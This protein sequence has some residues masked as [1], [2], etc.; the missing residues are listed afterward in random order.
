MRTLG[1]ALLALLTLNARA[2][3][4]TNVET[5]MRATHTPAS[6]ERAARF[7]I[8]AAKSD[9]LVRAFA[10]GALRF[11]GHDHFVRARDFSG[12]VTLTPG[13]VTPATLSMRVRADSL[14]ET[15]DVFTAEQ[16]QIINRELREIVLE[17]DKYPEITFKSTDVLVESPA[18]GQFRVK[19]G[20]DLTLHGVARHVVI[21]AEVT[22]TGEELRAKGEFEISRKDFNVKATSA[23][24]GTVRVRDTLKVI[25]QIVARPA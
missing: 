7:Q 23:F 6:A 18:G 24:H 25:F 22:M 1:L 11:K 14:A 10:G 15:R 20:G 4:P 5:L 9:F 19:I 2:P 12:E 13:A 17:P 16:K 21:P 3:R 8:D